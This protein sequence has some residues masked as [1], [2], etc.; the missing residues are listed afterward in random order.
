MCAVVREPNLFYTPSPYKP[1]DKSKENNNGYFLK[2]IQVTEE[3]SFNTDEY[4]KNIGGL[5]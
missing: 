1:L 3:N 5:G 4:V 2:I